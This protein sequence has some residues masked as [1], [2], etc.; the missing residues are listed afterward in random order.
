MLI[1]STHVTSPVGLPPRI[2]ERRGRPGAED[3]SE[4]SADEADDADGTRECWKTDKG[5]AGAIKCVCSWLAL[6]SCFASM[7]S[8][9]S[10]AMWSV[11]VAVD[12]YPVDDMVDGCK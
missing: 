3:E 11:R 1:V 12:G 5:A 7:S 4:S 2:G 9:P 8:M 10:L 6:A